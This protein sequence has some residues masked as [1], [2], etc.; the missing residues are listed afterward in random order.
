MYNWQFPSWPNFNYNVQGIQSIILT[1]AQETGEI[2]GLLQGLSKELKNETL[3]Q[4]MLTEAIKTSEIEGE[5]ISREDVISSI[6]NNLGWNK[7][8]VS[9]KDK[10][11]SN[12]TALMLEVRKSFDQPL[13]LEM[14]QAW[15]R[16]LMAHADHVNPGEWRK[17]TAAMQIVSG[18]Y[19][20]EV[21]HFEA[22]P[23]SDV[24]R[25]MEAFV[26]WFNTVSF[27]VKGEMA[28]AVLKAA[29]AHLYFESIHPFEDGNG[30][31]GRAIA[32]LALSQSLGRP[33]M[34]SLSK[35]I[36]QH[37]KTYYEALKEAQRSM[38]ISAWIEYFASVILEAQRD[39]R[40]M[41]HFTLMKAK[42]FDSYKNDLN[43]RQLKAINKML[44]KG[45][46][47]FEGGMTAKKYV[48]ITKTS[49]ATATRDLLAL[50]TLG[51]LVQQGAG[52]SVKYHL[53]MNPQL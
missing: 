6:R 38:E 20:R 28:E 7:T 39:A 50:Q 12:V 8:L 31:I 47:G 26:H 49:K 2:L 14:L 10:R 23:S 3:M 15:H 42:F 22:P 24:A 27:P 5:F 36:E 35:I 44:E 21:V 29:I 45:T 41:V 18:T 16:T 32:E 25:E 33:V 34:L 30:R 51:V 40:N 52:R 46:E 37:K 9:I 53:N 17:G 19:G 4:L 48:S 11:A 1:F 13:T 43:E